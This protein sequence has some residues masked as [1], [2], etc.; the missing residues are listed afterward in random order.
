MT[1][2]SQKKPSNG[3]AG[4]GRDDEAP[5]TTPRGFAKL[6][7]LPCPC[8]SRLTLCS[9]AIKQFAQGAPGVAYRRR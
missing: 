1:R 5:E 4:Q 2:W 8:G 9:T 3:P 7:R 6:R